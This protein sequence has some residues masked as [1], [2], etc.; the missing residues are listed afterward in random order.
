MTGPS[1]AND[2]TRLPGAPS[3]SVAVGALRERVTRHLDAVLKMVSASELAI[4]E[5]GAPDRHAAA[6]R[7]YNALRGVRVAISAMHSSLDELTDSASEFQ[8]AAT[9]TLN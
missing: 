1:D 4:T 8:R 3:L 9:R 6:L 7:F 2:E 5:G